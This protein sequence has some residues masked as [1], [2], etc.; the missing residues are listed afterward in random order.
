MISPPTQRETFT[1]NQ[2][3]SPIDV[4]NSLTEYWS[5]KVVAE[6]ND[7]YVK[8]AKLKGSFVWHKHEHE[9]EMFIVLKGQLIIELRD[10]KIELDAGDMYVVA[11]GVEHNPIAEEVCLVM[12]I[13]NKS[14]LHTGNIIDEKSKSIQE[15][16][17]G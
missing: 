9:D 8:V 3:L 15:Q 6:V 2:K 5:P 7:S 14:T 16:L 12:L 11:K 13:E 1:M 17:T 4:A 10:T